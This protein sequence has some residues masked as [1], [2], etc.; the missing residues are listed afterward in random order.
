MHF[1]RG[2]KVIF[3]IVR[4][5]V[6]HYD[7]SFEMETHVLSLQTLT[8]RFSVIAMMRIQN[9][10]KEEDFGSVIGVREGS[11]EFFSHGQTS[12]QLGAYVGLSAPAQRS[13]MRVVRVRQS[14]EPVFVHTSRCAAFC[15]PFFAVLYRCGR[16]PFP[17]CLWVRIAG[18]FQTGTY[19]IDAPSLRWC[20]LE[21][22]LPP[23]PL[24]LHGTTLRPFVAISGRH[25]PGHCP[26]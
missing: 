22:G 6:D 20:F 15:K 10:K 7:S 2:Y 11:S 13:S 5:Y 17:A 1:H 24:R 3:G 16:S 4:A 14:E 21:N 23:L 26:I 8:M 12:S 18:V 9:I 19:L 25:F